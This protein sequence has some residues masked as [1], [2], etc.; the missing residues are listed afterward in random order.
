N[1][2]GAVDSAPDPLRDI[3]RDLVRCAVERGADA[4]G[5]AVGGGGGGKAAGLDAAAAGGGQR[6]VVGHDHLA[7][8]C[9]I[10]EPLQLAIHYQA[11]IERGLAGVEDDAA[12]RPAN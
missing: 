7:A 3:E 5:G 4:G 6:S 2:R 9:I 10:A 1:T 11:R 8:R 12:G